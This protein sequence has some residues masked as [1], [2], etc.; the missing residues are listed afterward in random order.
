MANSRGKGM[1]QTPP[2]RCNQQ[3]PDYG[4]LYRPSFCSG[5]IT[6][7]HKK[8]E[9]LQIKRNLRTYQPIIM[10]RPFLDPESNKQAIKQN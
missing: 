4:K 9:N 7:K 3:N 6:R 8:E 10:Y 5:K 1:C 2:Q